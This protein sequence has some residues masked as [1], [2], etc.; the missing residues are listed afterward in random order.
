MLRRRAASKSGLKKKKI[1]EYTRYTPNVANNSLQHAAVQGQRL[2]LQKV[3]V[4]SVSS[5]LKGTTPPIET[6]KKKKKIIIALS[7][8]AA[9]VSQ[10]RDLDRL[11][12][13][14]VQTQL[15]ARVFLLI[16]AGVRLLLLLSLRDINVTGVRFRSSKPGPRASQTAAKN[17]PKRKQA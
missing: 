3:C 2:H 16:T 1:Q 7:Y 14:Q 8:E 10:A 13:K 17:S 15:L 5:R 12:Y 9:K 11:Q 6:F 4:I